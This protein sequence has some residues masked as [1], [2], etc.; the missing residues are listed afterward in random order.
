VLVYYL[1]FL[2][3]ILNGL[4]L[5]WPKDA[6]HFVLF[7]ATIPIRFIGVSL[8]QCVC[9]DRSFHWTTVLFSEKE[10]LEDE[11]EH[12]SWLKWLPIK[13]S[14]FGV[15]LKSGEHCMRVSRE[16]LFFI[17]I[18]FK[19]SDSVKCYT[20]L[21]TMAG[22]GYLYYVCLHL[23]QSDLYD[24]SWLSEVVS[25][26]RNTIG[27]EAD[28]SDITFLCLYIF[29]R[30][31]LRLFE[32]V[33]MLA[34]FTEREVGGRKDIGKVKYLMGFIFGFKRRKYK[35]EQRGG[36]GSKAGLYEDN[37]FNLRMVNFELLFVRLF[38]RE[39]TFL[40]Y[41]RRNR[42]WKQ[43]LKNHMTLHK[44][45]VCG[46][47]ACF[48]TFIVNFFEEHQWKQERMSYEDCQ[49]SGGRCSSEIDA[50][51]CWCTINLVTHIPTFLFVAG[52]GYLGVTSAMRAV[53]SSIFEIWLQPKYVK[54]TW[55][56]GSEGGDQLTLSH[57][58]DVTVAYY[59]FP[60]SEDWR[61]KIDEW[62]DENNSC[63]LT[64]EQ[65]DEVFKPKPKRFDV[66]VNIKSFLYQGT[67]SFRLNR[68]NNAPDQPILIVKGE[69]RGG[70]S[71]P[72]SY[73]RKIISYDAIQTVYID[74]VEQKNKSE[75][76]VFYEPTWTQKPPVYEDEGTSIQETEL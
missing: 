43:M 46:L 66:T 23:F 31:M 58:A 67:T 19:E 26:I 63:S 16:H 71:T 48:V 74:A 35:F 13:M 53:V 37:V 11:T 30:T 17:D 27:Y 4:W 65:L 3:D 39:D 29:L 22:I 6:V 51:Y 44:D 70:R 20:N 60:R 8:L 55:A 73:V 18:N 15:T 38:C 33:Y 14:R 75:D 49:S 32:R 54:S 9:C 68:V 62:C 76:D 24:N 36:R 57:T 61:N 25:V 41:R 5:V 47:L 40:M 34:E 28:I 12:H 1:D 52:V 59:G 21:A 7:F 2:L 10:S 45:M 56:I 64:L 72:D 69:W 42:N 50:E